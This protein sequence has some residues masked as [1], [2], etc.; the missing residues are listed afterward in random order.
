MNKQQKDRMKRTFMVSFMV[1]ACCLPGYAG[2][3]APSFLAGNHSV[4]NIL[5]S[6]KITC[7]VKDNFG[8]VIG[9]N[10]SVKGTTIGAITDMDGK[11]SFEAPDDG[12]L[13]VSFIGYTTQEIPLKGKTDFNITLSED[14]EMLDEVVV[15]GYG[16]QKK[17]NLSGSVA[18]IDGEQIAAKRSFCFAGR[19]AGCYYYSWR[20]STRFGRSCNTN[21]WVLFGE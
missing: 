15:V 21:S 13:V 12:I 9:A 17:V 18:A 5:N 8:P 19:N 4:E 16:V 10:V 1:G 11:F 20:W 14:N 6:K 3:S 2:N 7:V